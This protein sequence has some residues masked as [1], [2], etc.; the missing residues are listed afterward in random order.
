MHS[1]VMEGLEVAGSDRRFPPSAPTWILF[2]RP[3][4][5]VRGTTQNQRVS[6]V[7]RAGHAKTSG[8][9]RS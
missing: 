3:P 5:K 4:T 6:L 2:S 1:M 8:L 7:T 9:N